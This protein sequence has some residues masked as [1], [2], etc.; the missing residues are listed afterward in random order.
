MAVL[1]VL[2]TSGG[3]PSVARPPACA[4]F[5]FSC[6]GR[7]LFCLPLPARLP[8]ASHLLV[9]LV[10]C[11]VAAAKLRQEVEAAEAE[12]VVLQGTNG[13]PPAKV[14]EEEGQRAQQQH[15]GHKHRKAE[16]KKS[17]PA[18]KKDSNP[19]VP[20]SEASKSVMAACKLAAKQ[21]H[22]GGE[23]GGA[24]AAVAAG[25]LEA[26]TAGS[27]GAVVQ[28][29]AAEEPVEVTANARPA[30]KQAAGRRGG[31]TLEEEVM[32]VEVEA[33]ARKRQGALLRCWCPALCC[34]VF[35]WAEGQA[36]WAHSMRG[37][38]WAGTCFT[39]QLA[40]VLH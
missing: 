28:A 7:R 38:R 13:S 22:A 37:S 35:C 11:C 34:L 1:F 14:V 20:A 32:V 40:R 39:N 17:K 5:L 4:C 16:N 27:N 33:P 18:A 9:F 25:V 2:I 21:Q 36:P 10:W 6:V 24:T 8:R 19:S 31:A 12:K 15:R 30:K 26:S 3:H 29:P 23:E